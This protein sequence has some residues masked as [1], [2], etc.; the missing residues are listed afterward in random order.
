[1]LDD[2]NPLDEELGYVE[3]YKGF[4]EQVKALQQSNSQKEIEISALK[5]VIEASQVP[6]VFT[7]GKTDAALLK[8]A[9][10]RLGLTGFEHWDIR[11]IQSQKASNNETL[12][13]YLCELKDNMQL[14]MLVIGMFDRDTKLPIVADNETID[15]RN[16][17]FVKISDKFYAFSI[18]VPHE[19]SETEQISIEHYFT[20]EEIKTEIEGKRL[21]M[22]N[23][24]YKT[25]VF[26]GDARFYY[27]G[28]QSVCD[29]I[30]IIEHESNKYVTNLDGS[31]D[32]SISKARFVEWRLSQRLCKPPKWCRIG[33]VQ[34]R[35][36]KWIEKAAAQ[37][38]KPGE[39]R[40]ESC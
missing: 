18:P 29:T 20:N 3:L 27:K 22:G 39:R 37:K 17:E 31:G 16:K 28:A 36:N 9:I 12:L 11:T 26:K 25:G 5:K 34:R 35:K 7:E 32:Y 21:F 38:K 14:P 4:I 8:L 13:R 1:M 15:I 23:E 6:I 19:R 30:K 33:A 24:F 40:S 2:Q 10:K